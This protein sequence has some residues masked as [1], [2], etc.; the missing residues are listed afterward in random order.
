M[1]RMAVPLLITA[2][3]SGCAAS[4]PVVKSCRMVLDWN[5]AA[6]ERERAMWL[7][8]LMF[9]AN[10]RGPAK[11]CTSVETIVLPTFD[12]EVDARTKTVRTY[13]EIRIKDP[14]LDLRYFNDLATVAHAGFMREYTW[15]YLRQ[16]AWH[17]PR[18][19]RLAEFEQWRRAH[20]GNHQVE[21]QG[22]IAAVEE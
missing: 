18:G 9:R 4:R 12:E 3:L 16:R 15:V 11:K 5:T 20:L 21:T 22:S 19:L 10:Y 1:R 6:P 8:Y 13:Q 2:F 14:E 17:E 7:A